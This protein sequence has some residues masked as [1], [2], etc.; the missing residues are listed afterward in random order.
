MIRKWRPHWMN[1]RILF[2]I[3]HGRKPDIKQHIT[4]ELHKFLLK[5]IL[6]LK[7]FNKYF[8]NFF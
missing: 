1:C 3:D 7:K 8:E 6:K 4:T 5:N 2:S